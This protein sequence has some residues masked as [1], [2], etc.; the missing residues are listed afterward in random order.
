M[1]ARR[2]S[3]IF[4]LI[5]ILLFMLLGSP[6]KNLAPYDKPFWNIFENSPFSG[7]NRVNWGGW[8]GS[9]KFNFHWNPPLFV[10]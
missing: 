10:T 8:G 9:P 4:I 3:P 1:G 2:G 6:H 5:G 7:Q